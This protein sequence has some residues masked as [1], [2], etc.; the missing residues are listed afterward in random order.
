MDH[1]NDATEMSV[2]ALL[3][4]LGPS[5]FTA[6]SD[7]VRALEADPET[8]WS[9]VDLGASRDHLSDMDRLVTNTVVE[10]AELADGIRA[11]VGGDPETL[12]TLRPM[13]PAHAA[14]LHTDAR[15]VVAVSEEADSVTLT[16]TSAYAA[17]DRALTMPGRLP[18]IQ[19]ASAVR[20]TAASSP[21][22][23]R[24]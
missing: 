9:K 20:C 7:V 16:V 15:R 21:R 22:G 24:L 4:E 11:V 23:V 3:T 18:S 17:S 19:A 8:D 6:L 1:G 2:G 12:A 14:E 5:A 13:V 10:E